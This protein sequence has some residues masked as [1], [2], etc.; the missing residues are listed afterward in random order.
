MTIVPD[1]DPEKCQGNPLVA[2]TQQDDGERQLLAGLGGPDHTIAGLLARRD[3]ERRSRLRRRLRRV[4]GQLRVGAEVSVGAGVGA[5]LLA[6]VQ[7]AGPIDC[8]RHFGGGL[9]G[10]AGAFVSVWLIVFIP[11]A[12]HK[13][14]YDEFTN[15]RESDATMTI[16]PTRLATIAALL[17]AV[18]WAAVGFGGAAFHTDGALCALAGAV[19]AVLLGIAKQKARRWGQPHGQADKGTRQTRGQVQ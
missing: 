10:G 14:V 11:Q 6:A 16:W 7:G 17:A 8:L 4:F 5:G 9:C 12:K 13:L 19:G 15:R 18:Y 2:P 3:T 1:R